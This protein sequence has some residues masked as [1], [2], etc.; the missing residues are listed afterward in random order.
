MAREAHSPSGAQEIRQQFVN[1]LF[2]K[3]DAAWRRLPARQRAQ[4]K[5]E[6]IACVK[7]Y[8]K[9]MIVIPYS[10]VGIRGDC[11]ILLWR[12]GFDLSAFQQMSADLLATGLG[13][14]M[15]T[16]YSYL[17]MTKRSIYVDK[18]VHEG[19]EGRRLTI[20]PGEFKYLFVYPFV[21]TREWYLLSQEKRQEM[22]DE[23]IRIGHQFPTVRLNTTYSFGLDDQEFVVAFESD[24]PDHFLDLVMKL[25]G[26]EGSRFTLR[27]TPIFTCAHHELP[28]VLDLLGG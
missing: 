19:Q 13:K 8:K 22:M 26:V 20:H 11:D 14:F 18:H 9:T 24:K 6:F 10:L 28:K 1:F 15:T 16:P 4:G 23:H 25:R 21:K 7:K 5:R 3:L 2:L 17:A 27:D 12:I